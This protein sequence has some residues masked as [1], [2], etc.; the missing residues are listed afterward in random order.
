MA[1]SSV[2]TVCRVSTKR[3]RNVAMVVV[4][5]A[6]RVRTTDSVSRVVT[7]ETASRANSA[8][9]QLLNSSRALT[10]SNNRQ[11]PVRANSRVMV[12]VSK[13][14][15]TT[16]AVV[17]TTAERTAENVK[18]KL[19]QMTDATKTKR[20]SSD[21]NVS[22]SLL[23]CVAVAILVCLG[24][25]SPK[26]SSY[27]E[28]SDVP[29]AGWT[30]NSPLYFTPQYGDSLGYYDIAVA[31]RHDQAY[32]YRNLSITADFIGDNYRLKRRIINVELAD[33]Y[34]TWKGSGFGALYQFKQ[35]VL[36]HVPA[37]SI[38]RIVLWQSMSNRDTVSNINDVGIIITP[39]ND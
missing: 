4:V 33:K 37:H 12:E 32:A 16:V 9:L 14:E 35:V 11:S 30:H 25:C 2:R 31:I 1:T 7:D 27:S 8:M 22:I 29:E 10:N 20:T 3:R 34:G 24:A 5:V 13:T 17:V 26:H 19:E 39:S 21:S 6:V 38:H 23:T 36:T 28:F 15:T 18:R